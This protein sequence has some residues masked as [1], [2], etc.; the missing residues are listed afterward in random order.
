MTD[1]LKER[2]LNPMWVH[3][4]LPPE[5]PYLDD[6][7]TLADLKEA[8]VR[9]EA[10]EAEN[11][12]LAAGLCSYHYGDEHGHS[13]CRRIDELEEIVACAKIADRLALERI[14]AIEA[15]NKRLEPYVG[16]FQREEDRADKLGRQND[17]LKAQIGIL[18]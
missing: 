15:E 6:E 18:K 3:S 8:L 13:R 17:E 12:A 1:D 11:F 7:S 5:K 4:N 10:L 9:I 14:E 16:A 2:L